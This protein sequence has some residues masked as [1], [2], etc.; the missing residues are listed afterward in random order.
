MKQRTDPRP[1]HPYVRAA[2]LVG[3][4]ACV[5]AIAAMPIT[6][7]AAPLDPIVLESLDGTRTPLT[8]LRG[9]T[10]VLV[11]G[12]LDHSRT[13][14]ACD[15]LAT[16]LK[17]PPLDDWDVQTVLIATR[18]QTAPESHALPNLILLD[19]RREAFG[20][21]HVIVMPMVV[22]LAPDGQVVHAM[23][24][25]LP[26][27]TDLVTAAVPLAQ[28]AIS[29]E[30][31]DQLVNLPEQDRPTED[32]LRAVRLTD[33]ADE[34]LQHGMPGAAADRY[35]EAHTLKPDLGH[36]R[37]GDQANRGAL[38]GEIGD[39]RAMA[40]AG[41]RARQLLERLR[42]ARAENEGGAT[43]GEC[44]SDR[45]PEATRRAGQQDAP[46]GQL[47]RSNLAASHRSNR[48]ASRGEPA[49]STE[50]GRRLL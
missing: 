10:H 33:M 47:H 25:F 27:M 39:E 30:Q 6:Q 45:A 4:L 49:R 38:V 44:P 7:P 48:A 5:A 20:A 29:T 9:R 8:E 36:A 13:M 16:L 41:Q 31:F 28:G 17:Q 34:M 21:L 22:V 18:A 42:L 19:P 23:P 1:P 43:A 37:L 11:F 24:G 12:E 15:E 40:G 35:A 14:R 3:A 32:E 46:S 2:A 50:R 26:R